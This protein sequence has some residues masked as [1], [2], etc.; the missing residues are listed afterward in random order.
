MTSIIVPA[1]IIG[2]IRI[3]KYVLETSF[4]VMNSELDITIDDSIAEPKG[5]IEKTPIRRYYQ[6]LALNSNEAICVDDVNNAYDQQL[7]L[8]NEQRKY[9]IESQYKLNEYQAAKDFLIDFCDYGG[10]RN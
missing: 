9:G 1:C 2:F 7:D 3:V 10:N 8:I 6:L 4:P 5:N